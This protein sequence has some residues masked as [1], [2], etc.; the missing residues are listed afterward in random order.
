MLGALLA[1]F[2]FTAYAG[3]RRPQDP[4]V[5]DGV[6]QAGSCVRI[7]GV[8]AREVSCHG[9]YAGVVESL[10]P[11]G[12]TCEATLAAF[13]DPRGSGG[14]ACGSTSGGVGRPEG[15]W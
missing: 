1:I 5:V 10:P 9:A 11:L 2:V 15:R 8:L 6:L 3:S 7:D 14:C 13:D 12:S 4:L